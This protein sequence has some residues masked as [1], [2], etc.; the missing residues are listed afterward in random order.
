[1]LSGFWHPNGEDDYGNE[2]GGAKGKKGGAVSEV[3]DYHSGGQST[4]RGTDPLDRRDRALSQVVT[5]GASH[6][7]SDH[8]G[9]EGAE[10]PGTDTIEHLDADQPRR[11]GK[12]PVILMAG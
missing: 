7:I 3:I 8:Q 9:R 4:Q 6:D 1:L 5:P 12:V 10:N 2:G 11:I